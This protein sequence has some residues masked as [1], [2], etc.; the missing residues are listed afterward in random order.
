MINGLEYSFRPD[1]VFPTTN[2]YD[3]ITRDK[4]PS[5]NI[6]NPLSNTSWL[7]YSTGILKSGGLASAFMLMEVAHT[8]FYRLP[9][10]T[11]HIDN[12]H[13]EK[14]FWNSMP[15]TPTTELRSPIPA[16]R[17]VGNDISSV[18]Y[19]V[20]RLIIFLRMGC[21]KCGSIFYSLISSKI[22]GDTILYERPLK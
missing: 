2:Q 13:D 12:N 8:H 9:N 22:S 6:P 18:R 16:R 17:L 14:F 11:G 15:T 21:I 1:I 4:S 5:S 7:S 19:Q 10:R 20:S 3:R